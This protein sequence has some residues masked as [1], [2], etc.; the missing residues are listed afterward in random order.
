MIVLVSFKDLG[1]SVR[2]INRES[3]LV[4][5]Q[6][7]VTTDY[8]VCV[9]TDM[10]VE[11]FRY[12]HDAINSFHIKLAMLYWAMIYHDYSDIGKIRPDVKHHRRHS[13]KLYELWKIAN[14][15]KLS[16]LS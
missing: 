11:F 16:K 2:K 6:V 13:K 8:L 9:D 1:N 15:Q 14:E 7:V 4:K 12:R 3:W 10:N 5:V